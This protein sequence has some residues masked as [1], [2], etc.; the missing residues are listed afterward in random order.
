MGARRLGRYSV[1]ED[2]GRLVVRRAEGTF[3]SAGCLLSALFFVASYAVIFLG[4]LAGRNAPELAM[5]SLV[6]GFI[7]LSLLICS[8][9]FGAVQRVVYTLDRVKN[10]L[11]DGTRRLGSLDKI[12]HIVVQSREAVSAMGRGRLHH[13][14]SVVIAEAEGGRIEL[15]SFAD[16]V[17]AN[18]FSD[19]ISSFLGV[20]ISFEQGGIVEVKIADSDI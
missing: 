1:Q 8:F 2:N 13:D 3:D 5:Y 12:R 11:R 7:G 15:A 14:Q 19:Q 20:P 10:E 17:H 9:V 18:R 6:L 4:A 16:R